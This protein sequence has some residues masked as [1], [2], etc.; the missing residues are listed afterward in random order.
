MIYIVQFWHHT[1]PW[2]GSDKERKNTA[3]KTLNTLRSGSGRRNFFPNPLLRLL[4]HKSIICFS[5]FY[6]SSAVRHFTDISKS[7]LWSRVCS[8]KLSAGHNDF[9]WVRSIWQIRWG[10][11]RRAL[12]R[13]DRRYSERWECYQLWNRDWNQNAREVHV[14]F[15]FAGKTLLITNIHKRLTNAHQRKYLIDFDSVSSFDVQ[16]IYDSCCE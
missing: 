14:A 16:S 1:S 13:H 7:R 10:S 2:E 9:H 12:S 8:I 15:G 11:K 3:P 4:A 5:A 6:C